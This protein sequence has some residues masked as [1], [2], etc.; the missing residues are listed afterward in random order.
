MIGCQP[1]DRTVPPMAGSLLDRVL[2]GN[3]RAVANAE[4][5]RLRR[6]T[7]DRIVA[8]LVA[9]LARRT[10]PHH[11]SDVDGAGDVR[12]AAVEPAA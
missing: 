1:E 2:L 3:G 11:L 4:Q 5:D 7:E 8:D 9:S 10:A 12:P 6:R